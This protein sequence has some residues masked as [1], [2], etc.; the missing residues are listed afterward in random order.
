MSSTELEYH[1]RLTIVGCGAEQHWNVCSA[2]VALGDDKLFCIDNTAVLYNIAGDC[3]VVL[4]RL[5][6]YC[7][8]ASDL[9][10]NGGLVASQAPE[11]LLTC[12]GVGFVHGIVR[13]VGGTIVA[14]ESEST[15]STKIALRNR[16]G[17]QVLADDS[18]R[19]EKSANRSC[20]SAP[21]DL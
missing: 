3:V 21:A 10:V 18:W 14:I 7:L 19:A 17:N 12:D 9:R 16:S 20:A 8:Q 2:T 15:T 5:S 13:A 1:N 6:R 11:D 4:D